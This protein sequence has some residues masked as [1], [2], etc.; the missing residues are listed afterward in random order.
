MY[1]LNILEVN[2]TRIGG[3]ESVAV[4]SHII[5]SCVI[6]LLNKYHLNS[7]KKSFV[8]E[9]G[10]EATGLVEG[11][12]GMRVGGKRTIQGPAKWWYGA[13]ASPEGILPDISLV[14]EVEL[15]EVI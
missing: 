1:S 9:V 10:G 2:D 3:G 15:L 7:E 5:I 11:V 6:R 13:D 8:V 12:M 14:F 4:G